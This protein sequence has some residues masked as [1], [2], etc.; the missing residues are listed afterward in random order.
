M[1]YNIARTRLCDWDVTWSSYSFGA[2][3]KVTPDITIKTAPI[4]VG[5]VGD[6]ELGSRVISVDGTVKVE[7]R[8]ID[9]TAL[10]GVMPWY[11]SGSIPLN[12]ATVHE[13]MYS[14]AA[15]LNLHPTDVASGTLTQDLN[16][17]MA[18]PMIQ[19]M[20]ADGKTDGKVL[21]T[22]KFYPDRSQLPALVYGYV[23][24]PPS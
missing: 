7:M 1:A 23:G 14:Y 4:K 12:P 8:E 11:T 6:V 19:M 13:D 17:L 5:S 24:A 18:V 16:L 20:E 9:L 2:V 3:D 22:F 10:Q 15:I 21:V